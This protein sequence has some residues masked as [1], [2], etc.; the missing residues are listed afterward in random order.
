M[1]A[2]VDTMAYNEAEGAP[3]HRLGTPVKGAMTA[4]EA[5]TKGGVDWAVAKQPLRTTTGI[6]VPDHFAVVR[7]DRKEVL[8]VV[9]GQYKPLQNAAAFKFFDG[10][11]G[12]GAAIYH[13]VGSLRGGRVIWILAKLPGEIVVGRDDRVDKYLLLSNSHDKSMAVRIGFTPIRVVCYNTLRAAINSMV[14]SVRIPHRGNFMEEFKNAQEAL[15]L[16]NR[17]FEHAEGAFRVLSQSR[18]SDGRLSEYLLRL[19]PEPKMPADKAKLEAYEDE[20][21]HL[22]EIRSRVAELAQVGRG[23]NLPGVRGTLWGAYN[24]V[25]DYADHDYRGSAEARL[26]SA[27]FGTRSNLKLEAFQL[28]VELSRN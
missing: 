11:V 28:A 8:S 6:N 16:A 25:T 26:E 15:G 9:S 14:D 21:Y 23:T 4:E 5:I 13:T 10:V 18:C 24:A 19:F 3:W 20:K 2:Y 12:H 7:M 17:W 27:W 1:P 22:I